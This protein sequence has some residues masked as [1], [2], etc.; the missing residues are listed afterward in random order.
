L[1]TPVGKFT[2]KWKEGTKREINGWLDEMEKLAS[3]ELEY[4]TLNT[5]N[6]TVFVFGKAA[7]NSVVEVVHGE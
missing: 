1:H 5:I 6:G 2:G 4:L 7:E 3:G